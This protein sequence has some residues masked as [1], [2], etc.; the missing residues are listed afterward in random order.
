[1][2]N[3]PTL[4]RAQIEPELEVPPFPEIFRAHAPYA[5]RLLARLG[6]PRADVPDACQDVFLTVHRRLLDFDPARGSLR[7]WIYGICV[8]TAAD[9]RRKRRVR[10]EQCEEFVAETSVPAP[11]HQELERRSA[12]ARLEQVLQDLD[13]GKRAVFVLYEFEGLSMKEIANVLGCPLQ[14]AYSRLHAARAAVFS[15]FGAEPKVAR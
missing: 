15:A 10:N 13:Q 12:R 11:Q 4:S 6:V 3:E 1:L 9:Q 14:T 2:R 7:N 8:R 5:L